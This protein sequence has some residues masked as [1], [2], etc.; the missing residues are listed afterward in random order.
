VDRARLGDERAW[1][2]LFRR[3][4]PKLLAYAS[5]RLPTSEQ[6][7]DA[8]GETMTR[9]VANIGRFRG[10][11]GG[12]DAWVYGIVRHVVVDEQRKLCREGPGLVPDVPDQGPSPSDRAL[13]REDLAAVREAFVQLSH[14]DQ[15]LLEL[16][17]VA[18]LSAGDVASVLGRRPG[19]IRMAQSRALSRLRAL[20]PPE[21]E[22]VADG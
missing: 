9:A 17:I 2:H 18:E 1:E 15:E 6:A 12:Y 20:L 22:G 14:S 19:A 4:Y 10:D 16:R 11:G 21:M 13:D 8:V 7:K 5:R 3:S